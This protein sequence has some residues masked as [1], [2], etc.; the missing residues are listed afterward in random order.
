MPLITEDRIL[1]TISNPACAGDW[2]KVDGAG[3]KFNTSKVRPAAGRPKVV[4]KGEFEA[5]NITTTRY[6]DAVRDSQLIAL[7]NSGNALEGTTITVMA[8]DSAGITAGA[9]QVYS[10][11]AVESFKLPAGDSSGDKLAEIEITWQVGSL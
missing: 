7:L 5:E 3:G 10:G 8:L 2:Y 4:V 1:V 11:C 9:P 6:Y